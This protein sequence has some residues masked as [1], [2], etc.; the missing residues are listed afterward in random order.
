MKALIERSVNRIFNRFTIT[1]LLILIQIGWFAVALLRL[2]E[3]SVWVSVFFTA[4]AVL[5]ALFITWRDDSPA[6]KTGWILLICILPVF[7]VT[8]YAFFGNKRPS[9]GLKRKMEVPDQKHRKELK[10]EDD[11]SA[12]ASVRLMDTINYIGKKRRVSGVDRNPEQILCA[13]R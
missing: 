13:G 7:G 8:M 4:A 12:Q 5:M 11:V 6:Y 1:I 2:S 9:R 10:Q 3:Y